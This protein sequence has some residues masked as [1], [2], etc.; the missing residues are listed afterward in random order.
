MTTVQKWVFVRRRPYYLCHSTFLMTFHTYIDCKSF[1]IIN[2][3]NISVADFPVYCVI[4]LEYYHNF[5]NKLKICYE[6][7]L[8]KFFSCLQKEHK[9]VFWEL[10]LHK[11][12]L[13]ALGKNIIANPNNRR[14]IFQNVI[15]SQYMK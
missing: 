14:E 9:I 13:G 15:L 12:V 5:T 4:I 1:L 2:Q 11:T 7:L 6:N 8:Q 10:L 3:M